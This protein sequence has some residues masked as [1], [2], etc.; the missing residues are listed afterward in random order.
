MRVAARLAYWGPAY[1]GYARQPDVD[2]VEADLIQAL[3]RI[4]AI[5]DPASA[6]LAVA[7]RTDRGVSAVANVVAF[8]TAIPWARLPS[9]TAGR[10]HDAWLDQKSVV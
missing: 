8:D 2:T 4:R 1:H 5:R 9:A 7:S 10:M 3:R 6:R